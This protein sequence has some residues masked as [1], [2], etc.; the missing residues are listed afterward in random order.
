MSSYKDN[1]L[2][3]AFLFIPQSNLFTDAFT[4]PQ[5]IWNFTGNILLRASYFGEQ[6]KKQIP[7]TES[8][9]DSAKKISSVAARINF[10]YET[11]KKHAPAKPEQTRHADDIVEAWNEKTGNTAELNLIL[12][13]LLQKA[14]VQCY[15]LLVSTR[16]HGKVNTDFPSAGQLNGVD[17]LALDST[18]AYVMDPSIKFQSFRNPPFNVMNRKAFALIPGLAQQG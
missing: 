8:L 11:V 13:N 9:I 1:L 16:E 7:G 3:V 2:R 17:A 12:L 14:N 18:T 4:S 5:T 15:P 6:I 10:I